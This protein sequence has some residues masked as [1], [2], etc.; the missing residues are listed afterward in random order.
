MNTDFLY[1]ICEQ[2]LFFDDGFMELNTQ[3]TDCTIFLELDFLSQV[4]LL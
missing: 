4:I 3:T 2:I 1:I